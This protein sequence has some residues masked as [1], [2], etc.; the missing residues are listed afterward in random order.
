MNLTK[1]FSIGF[2]LGISVSMFGQ[3]DSTEAYEPDSSN[4]V[5]IVI[6]G[7]NL[8]DA[9][10][11]QNVSGLLQSSRDVYARTAGF[12]FSAARFR[13]RGYGSENTLIS[14]GGIP[15]N[16]PETGWAIWSYWGG[17]NDITRYPVITTG[18]KS[19]TEL[20][21]G[22]GGASYVDLRA[23]TKRAGNRLSYAVTNRS[24]RNR[25]MYTYNSG[26]TKKGWS[27]SGSLSH[28][29]AKE[30]YVEGTYY[31]GISYFASVGKKINKHHE[32]NFSVLGAPTV[33]AR[34]GIS[35][36]EV[37]DLTGNNYYNP[38]WGY[39]TVD[40]KGTRE[41]RN[42]RVRNNHK[43]Y[44]LLT[45]DWKINSK[46]K[47]TTSV[48]AIVGKTSNTNLNWY[49]A[50]YP[51]PDYY[52]YRPSYLLSKG[53]IDGASA[54]EQAWKNDY[55]TSQINWDYMY[56]A[57]SKNLSTIQ[58]ANGSGQSVQGMRAEYIV[59]DYRVDPRQY[60][61][62]LNYQKEISDKLYLTAGANGQLY[63]SHNYKI[64]KDLMG[65]DF[66]VDVNKFAERNFPDPSIAQNDLS[67]PNKLVHEGDKFGYDYNIHVN[68]ASSFGQLDR[69]GKKIDSYVALQLSHTTFWR[70][71][72]MQNGRFPKTSKG[73]SA[74]QNFTNY[75]LK[76]GVTY[77][78]NGR[79][80]IHVNG[81]NATRAPYSKAS[82][83]SPRTRGQVID[84]LKNTK[85][86]SGDFNYVI[87]YPKLKVRA[88]G[89]YTQIND[90]VWSRSFYHDVY[91]SY[92]NYAMT[93]VDQS[94]KGVEFGLDATVATAW[95]VTAAFTKAQ[96]LY[97]SRPLA[98][99]TVN[100]SSELL[101]KDKVVYLKNY[102]IGGMPETAASIGLKYNSP[103]YWYIG[104]NYNYFA[105]IY[106]SPNPD[107]RTAEA[108]DGF[109]KGD[110]QVHQI[111]DQEK[112]DNG[113]SI[114]VY[115]GKSHK[116]HKKN[117]I[118]RINIIV[119][120]VTNNQN[121]KTGGYEQLRYDSQNIN[122][123]PPKYGYMY[124]RN[125]FVMAS[126]LF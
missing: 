17:L 91:Q 64:L 55:N 86:L 58:N 53:D 109:V 97:T 27:F 101:A 50:K 82:F 31:S 41:K 119:N 38:Y 35:V 7:S 34:R 70:E 73:N 12:N 62:N 8:M 122:K 96:Y 79:H 121:F 120:N 29:W 25:L 59:E 124:G 93:N 80:Y 92:V 28:R 48:Y 10:Q 68:K 47:L 43:P 115:L 78:I 108:L 113:S 9:G 103:K 54:L 94:Y 125:Y 19:N 18:I 5:P 32:L 104:A 61:I 95:N 118:L 1:L 24:Y 23:S 100:N 14:L 85:I 76:G 75:A 60:G 90:Q 99:V 88:T 114:N 51:K 4:V 123:F 6:L 83:I 44:F 39:Q 15:A 21:G 63:K 106:L 16:D 3:S 71:G 2:T 56:L 102:H 30:G 87:R 116:F 74:K 117:T 66:W 11:A 36:Q 67:T 22:I 126:Y 45:D 52:K 112:L 40:D 77:K 84:N 72:L 111:I 57:N 49:N 107:R 42:A 33:Q 81:E 110:P 46:S 65:A 13:M 105:D 69:K 98:T 26:V 89:F 37:Y 20:F